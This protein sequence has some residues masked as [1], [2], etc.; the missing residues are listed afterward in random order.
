MVKLGK[1]VR[2]RFERGMPEPLTRYHGNKLIDFKKSKKWVKHSD[3]GPGLA[4]T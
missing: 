3:K 2:G 4:K 1:A